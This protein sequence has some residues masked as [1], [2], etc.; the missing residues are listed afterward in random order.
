[1][2]SLYDTSARLPAKRTLLKVGLG[3]LCLA[4]VGAAGVAVSGLRY[5]SS[6]EATATASA[7]L[8][9]AARGD[10][11]LTCPG[12]FGRPGSTLRCSA[13]AIDDGQASGEIILVQDNHGSLTVQDLRFDAATQAPVPSASPPSDADR[14]AAELANASAEVSE[15]K[16]QHPDHTFSSVQE[17]DSPIDSPWLVSIDGKR[18][19]TWRWNDSTSTWQVD[20]VVL[21]MSQL[22][23]DT[24]T[25][26]DITG[27][28]RKDFLLNGT[29]SGDDKG[30]PFSAVLLHRGFTASPVSFKGLT[31][32]HYSAAFN[33]KWNGS[34]L[35]SDYGEVGYVTDP[36]EYE[37]TRFERKG[38]TSKVWIER[39]A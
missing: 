30:L 35:I 18:A 37:V 11:A 1:M 32:D 24:I 14:V 22:H 3:F 28:G 8:K 7:A 25:R 27:E 12:H 10:L 31:G 5:V 15:V 34:E 13:T 33:L 4:L 6:D 21:R 17:V 23:F 38:P 20:K 29:G 2:Q 39:P 16:S 9:S 19:L 26:A 36:G